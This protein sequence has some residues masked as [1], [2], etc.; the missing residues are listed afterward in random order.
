MPEPEAKQ[1][2]K[3]TWSSMALLSINLPE[4]MKEIISHGKTPQTFQSE[5]MAYISNALEQQKIAKQFDQ[6]GM[7]EM[8]IHHTR[9][10]VKIIEQLHSLRKDSYPEYQVLMAPFYYK[11]GE[12]LVSYIECNM[13]E[14][15][16]LKPLELPEDPEEEA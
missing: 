1:P 8:A 6:A 7:L 15:N 3:P 16:Q 5:D 11:Q 2:A 9:K 4:L 10:A 13:N 14:M 12:L